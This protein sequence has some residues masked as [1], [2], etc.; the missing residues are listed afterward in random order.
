MGSVRHRCLQVDGRFLNA[1]GDLA[2]YQA[3]ALGMHTGRQTAFNTAYLVDPVDNSKYA[4]SGPEYPSAVEALKNVSKPIG[5]T[6]AGTVGR[7]NPPDANFQVGSCITLAGF[8]IRLPVHQDT[9]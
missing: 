1:C 6:G 5:I 8:G 4:P 3:A 2:P 9:S 7:C